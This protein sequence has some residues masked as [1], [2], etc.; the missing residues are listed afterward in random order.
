ASGPL[1]FSGP[2]WGNLL[3]RCLTDVVCSGY[4]SEAVLATRDK[5]RALALDARTM[6]VFAAIS[7][8]I[9][10]D[11]RG[12]GLASAT[13]WRDRTIEF[14]QNRPSHVDQ[15]YLPV[16]SP[17]NLEVL[18]GAASALLSWGAPDLA[19]GVVSGGYLIKYKR[20]RDRTWK[21]LEILD[22]TAT[23]TRVSGLASGRYEFKVS[24]I[25]S[26]GTSAATKS[27][28]TWLGPARRGGHFISS[29]P[30]SPAGRD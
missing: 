12:A 22:P 8:Y 28:S 4:F 30:T 20:L 17:V 3:D 2:G 27:V 18:P 15:W 16:S 21:V 23:S 25:S 11:T 13:W 6:T 9:E 26:R 19:G 5:A 10:A 7:P 29:A 1:P 14:L 24:T